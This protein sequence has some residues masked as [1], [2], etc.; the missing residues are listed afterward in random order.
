MKRVTEEDEEPETMNIPPKN[1]KISN[2]SRRQKS[3][4]VVVTDLMVDRDNLKESQAYSITKKKD[5]PLIH[6]YQ[7]ETLEREASKKK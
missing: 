1:I 2:R 7:S 3:G 4:D 6:Q 5:A